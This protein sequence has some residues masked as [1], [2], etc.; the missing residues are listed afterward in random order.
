MVQVM[1]NFVCQL[2]LPMECPGIW[3][4]NI[5]GKSVKVFL[6]EIN[7]KIGGLNKADFLSKGGWGSLNSL[8]AWIEQRTDTSPSERGFFLHHC[9]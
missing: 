4:K 1:V 5:L 9:L 7:L 8:T 6:G 3:S 2:D